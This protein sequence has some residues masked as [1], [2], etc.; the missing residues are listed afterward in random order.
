MRRA[1]SMTSISLACLVG[2]LTGCTAE[3]G[4][5][6]FEP[7]TF[8]DT[9]VTDAGETSSTL[10]EG[11]GAGTMAGTWILVHERSSCVLGQEQVTL[12]KYRLEIEQNGPVV[13]ETRRL[14]STELTPI[15]G[16]GVNIDEAVLESIEFADVD[17]GIVST[18]RVGGTYSSSTEV[19]LWGLDLDNPLTDP[20]P[21]DPEDPAVVD[22]DGD[23]NP[24]VTYVI[25]ESGCERYNSQ[26]QIFRFTG[27][28]VKPNRIDG[29]STGLT[30]LEVYG[31][32]ESSCAIAPEIVSND[33]HS[34]FSMAR[35]DGLG[36][37]LNADTD[38][39]GTISCEEINAIEQ[40]L[41]EPREADNEN[42]QGL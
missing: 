38:G 34:R 24:G 23:E 17:D 2:C 27:E 25:G 18:V 21:S 5:G 8:S 28:F 19:A 20:I 26:R 10:G 16:L 36:G 1:V 32:S 15:L 41:F 7:Q 4:T 14:C 12:A 29:T 3:R 6:E 42:C 11:P 30:D 35:I 9:R 37:S 39:D 13:D 31:G 33:A 40:T 22:A